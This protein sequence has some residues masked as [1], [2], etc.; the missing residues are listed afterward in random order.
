MKLHV[1]AVGALVD[2]ATK[3]TGFTIQD[4]RSRFFLYSRHMEIRSVEILIGM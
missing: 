1:T 2:V 3:A 4:S